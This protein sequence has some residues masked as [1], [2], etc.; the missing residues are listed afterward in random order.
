MYSKR[1]SLTRLSSY[2]C[3]LYSSFYICIIFNF[4]YTDFS[5]IRFEAVCSLLGIISLQ[6]VLVT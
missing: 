6:P 1:D 2:G 5:N 3:I 4:L